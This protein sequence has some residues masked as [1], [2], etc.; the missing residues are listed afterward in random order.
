MGRP[1]QFNRDTV[2]D[3]AMHVFWRRGFEATSIQDLVEAT[4]LNRGSLYNEF[5]DKA[6]LFRAV[7]GHYAQSAPSSALLQAANDGPPRQTID[8]FFKDLIR[9]ART[10]ADHKGCL[11][12]NT[13]TELCALDDHIAAWI[14]DAVARLEDALTTLIK[15][16]QKDGS[17]SSKR[18]SRSLARFLLGCAQGMLVLSKVS[19]GTQ[20]LKDIADNALA[21]LD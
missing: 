17:I 19:T 13:A 7:M 14:G 8:T 12:T 21:A 4:G 3:A 6:G 2:L 18:K 11:I 5:A 1:A 15:R 20:P 9:R 10:D 16:G